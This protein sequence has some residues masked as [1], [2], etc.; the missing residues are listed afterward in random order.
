[1]TLWASVSVSEKETIFQGNTSTNIE[2]TV[3]RLKRVEEIQ[4]TSSRV[5]LLAQ[6]ADSAWSFKPKVNIVTADQHTAVF[7]IWPQDMI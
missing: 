7:S 1:M 5:T 4:L 2:L 3:F 6:D